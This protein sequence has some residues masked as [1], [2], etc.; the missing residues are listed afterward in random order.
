MRVM[1]S[2]KQN[3]IQESFLIYTSEIKINKNCLLK[4]FLK[5][6]K[7]TRPS[8]FPFLYRLPVCLYSFMLFSVSSNEKIC[9]CTIWA[10][11]H[12]ENKILCIN[13]PASFL[14]ASHIWKTGRKLYRKFQLITDIWELW[15]IRSFF[16]IK[17]TRE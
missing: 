8:L 7:G 2:A 16:I 17:T 1:S 11:L 9:I 14:S 3:Q 5:E 13:L 4:I 10:V 15:K 6:F 12:M